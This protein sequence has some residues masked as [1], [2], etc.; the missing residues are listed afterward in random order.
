M[1]TAKNTKIHK[2]AT[3]NST[4]YLYKSKM[5]RWTSIVL[6]VGKTGINRIIWDKIIMGL[7]ALIPIPGTAVR[8]FYRVV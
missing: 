8:T 3:K 5:T 1:L 2:K 4:N 7:V 6:S